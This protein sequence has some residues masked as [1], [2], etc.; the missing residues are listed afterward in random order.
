MT[1]A[2]VTLRKDKPAPG[3]AAEII[4]G[5]VETHDVTD[6][7]GRVFTLRK[8]QVLAQFRLVKMLDAE[9]AQN[10]SYVQMLFPVLFVAAIDGTP[11]GFPQSEREIEALIARLD[12]DG[13]VAVM[14]GVQAHWGGVAAQADRDETK[15]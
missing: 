11:Q 1:E 15:N 5:A 14:G 13:L 12:D 2:K 10:A 6:G 9:T 7:R 8:P 3:S 4:A